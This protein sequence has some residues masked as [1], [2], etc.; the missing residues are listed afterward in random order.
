MAKSVNCLAGWLWYSINMNQGF[1]CYF[2]LLFYPSSDLGGNCYESYMTDRLEQPSA[3][4]AFGGS[5]G[6]EK[7]QLFRR[8]QHPTHSG[9]RTLCLRGWMPPRL[10][11]KLAR[12][13]IVK[14]EGSAIA[15]GI[16]WA[17]IPSHHLGWMYSAPIN[18][19]V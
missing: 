12:T 8:S 7:K 11:A 3:A 5:E 9:R 15:V 2:C 16:L 19:T 17:A 13:R 14:E 18:R 6:G 10:G 1:V 4:S